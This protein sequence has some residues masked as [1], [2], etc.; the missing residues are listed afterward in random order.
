M[1]VDDRA[2]IKA[3]AR[4]DSVSVPPL[5]APLT[6][7]RISRDGPPKILAQKKS[8]DPPTSGLRY[9]DV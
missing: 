3:S 8:L 1:E 5:S 6:S 9:M 2:T 7:P 4:L